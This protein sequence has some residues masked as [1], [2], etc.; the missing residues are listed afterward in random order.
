MPPLEMHNR[1]M[2]IIKSSAN[3]CGFKK[4]LP[5]FNIAILINVGNIIVLH[6]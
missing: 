1:Y 6:K 2:I 4:C 5:V 3:F